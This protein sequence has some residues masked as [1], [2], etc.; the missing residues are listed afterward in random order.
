M[1]DFRQQPKGYEP[2]IYE[3]PFDQYRAIPALNSSKLK[4][5][6][7]TPAHFKAALEAPEKP[8][9]AVQQKAFNKGTAFDTLL[10]RGKAHLDAQV[11][12]DL[13]INKNKKEYKEFKAEAVAAGKMILS[14]ED[15]QACFKMLDASLKKYQWKKIFASAG[16]P[17][18]ILIWQDEATGLWCKAELDFLTEDG[19]LVDLKTTADAGFWFFSR[20]ARRL[21][22]VNQGAFYLSGLT[23]VTGHY[24]Y[25]FLIAAIEVDP[26]YE[27]HIFRPSPLQKYEAEDQNKERMETLLTCYNRDEWPGYLDCIIDLDSGQYE[28]ER[29]EDVESN[30]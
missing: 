3:M 21:G 26:P 2:G 4:E 12:I 30:F 15:Y 20:N 25:D 27:S 10:L 24:H 17:H 18:R 8:P 9:T 5:L 14:Q 19:T 22:Y 28:E 23:A 13:E 1:I 29:E 7:R 6:R 16:H 11:A